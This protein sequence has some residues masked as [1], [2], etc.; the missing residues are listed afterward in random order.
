[1]KAVEKFDPGKGYKF[2]TYAYW[3]IR[4]AITRAIAE[5][6]RTIRLPIH[7]QETLNKIAK[8]QQQLSQSTGCSATM[9]QLAGHYLSLGLALERVGDSKI[10]ELC[11]NYH[12]G[13]K[14]YEAAIKGIEEH[15]KFLRSRT[16]KNISLSCKIGRD[17]DTDLQDLLASDYEL[18][19]EV[20]QSERRERIREVVGHLDEREAKVICL[21]FG[22]DDG[23]EVSLA[24]VGKLLDLSRERV[25]QIESKALRK[26]RPKLKRFS[27]A[28]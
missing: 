4:Q 1:M 19:S 13:K 5:K 26:L 17:K 3:W 7:I 12:E 24:Q 6:S 14:T 11:R 22:L 8:A 20:I 15:L 2:S 23:V 18:E 21:R 28:I 16:R 9:R 25:R 27:Q 10:R